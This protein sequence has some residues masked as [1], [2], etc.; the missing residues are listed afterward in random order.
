[1]HAT[2]RE[3]HKLKIAVIAGG[4]DPYGLVNE[5]AKILVKFPEQFDVSLSS[6]TIFDAVLDSRFSY[7]KIGNHLDELTKNIDLISEYKIEIK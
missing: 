6:N 4:S 3:E 7:I 2:S 1:M 5:I